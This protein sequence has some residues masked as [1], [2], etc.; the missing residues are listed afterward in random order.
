MIAMVIA[1]VGLMGITILMR[2]IVNRRIELPALV[3]ELVATTGVGYVAG[4][5]LWVRTQHGA[6]SNVVVLFGWTMLFIIGV[7]CIRVVGSRLSRLAGKRDNNFETTKFVKP[8][9]YHASVLWKLLLIII[10]FGESSTQVVVSWPIMA[11]AGYLITA[12]AIIDSAVRLYYLTFETPIR[13]K[14]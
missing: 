14:E 7:L 9:A 2:K 13:F 12:G 10:V 11:L 1:L 4:L 3:G 6:K 8:L 5:I